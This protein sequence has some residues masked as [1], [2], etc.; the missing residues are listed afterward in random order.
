MKL[1]SIIIFVIYGTLGSVG[2]F[3]QHSQDA[4]THGQAHVTLVFE[5]RHL[6]VEMT[7]PAANMLGFEHQPRSDPQWKVHEKLNQKLQRPD[8]LIVLQ[9]AC[10][11]ESSMVELPFKRPEHDKSHEQHL[12]QAHH[13]NHE[14]DGEAYAEHRDIYSRYEWLCEHTAIPKLNFRY[15]NEYPDFKAISVLWIING[16]QGMSELNKRTRTLEIVQ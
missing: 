12:S 1:K 7:T 5:N 10:V 14:Q 9:P 6:V 8:E 4:H 15:F 2:A 3:A 13:H 11:L 16:K